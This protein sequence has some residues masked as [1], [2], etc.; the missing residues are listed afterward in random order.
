MVWLVIQYGCLTLHKVGN[1]LAP[2]SFSRLILWAL[3]EDLRVWLWI[4]MYWESCWSKLLY[5]LCS[6]RIWVTQVESIDREAKL[7]YKGLRF[8]RTNGFVYP[9]FEWSLR[10]TC[11]LISTTLYWYFQVIGSIRNRSHPLGNVRRPKNANTV[12]HQ[13]IIISTY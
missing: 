4:E 10:V 6:Y 5:I 12:T 7:H 3:K 2:H 8:E 13:S 11:S 1:L 9:P